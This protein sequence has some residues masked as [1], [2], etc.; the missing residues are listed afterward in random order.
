M[1]V[2]EYRCESCGLK[3]SVLFWPP[4]RPE[5][6]C[7]RCGSTK[8]R[9]L[10]SRVALLRSEE[11][12]LERL[13]DHVSGL[14]EDDPRSVERWAR[15]LG[16]EMGEELGEDFEQAL[17]EAESEASGEGGGAEDS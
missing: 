2:Y 15:R 10:V 1:P 11:D 5:P 8:A 3:F 14:D 6:R 12:R 4:D 17:E 16:K 9:R 13:A 7:R